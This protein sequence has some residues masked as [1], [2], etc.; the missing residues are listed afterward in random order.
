MSAASAFAPPSF[1]LDYPRRRRQRMPSMKG[2][3]DL[4]GIERS[5]GLRS[6][7]GI[8]RQTNKTAP[9]IQAI[10]DG[11]KRIS[12]AHV[13]SSNTEIRASRALKDEALQLL[14][15]HGPQIWPDP[16]EERPAWLE[17]PSTTAF[18]GKYPRDLYYNRPAD[19]EM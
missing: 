14:D 8:S 9:P 16:A 13:T 5:L 17:Q 2:E 19:R 11:I 6:T 12:K 1:F 7:R 15:D 3:R 10:L 4:V 18:D